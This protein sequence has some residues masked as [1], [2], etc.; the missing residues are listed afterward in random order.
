M[1]IKQHIEAGH[2]PKG[3]DGFWRV[4]TDDGKTATVCAIHPRNLRPLLGWDYAGV[5][6]WWSATGK[7]DFS[8]PDLLPPPPRKVPLAAGAIVDA[9]GRIIHFQMSREEAER[10]AAAWN[11]N[12]PHFNRP[13]RGV[14]LTGS[15]EEEWIK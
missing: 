13:L 6:R 1:N 8:G 15:Y 2:Y 7:R 10:V 14:E 5:Y 9:T 12:S 4:P 11:K 3:D